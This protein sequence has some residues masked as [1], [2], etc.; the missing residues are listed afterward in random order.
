MN[1]NKK[2]HCMFSVL[3]VF[4]PVHS[5]LTVFRTCRNKKS[6]RSSQPGFPVTAAIRAAGFSRGCN[7]FRCPDVGLR[8]LNVFFGASNL[9]F[10]PLRESLVHTL[11]LHPE[12]HS[13][14]S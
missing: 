10:M 8:Q 9:T 14:A 7:L 13:G 6:P 3:F 5:W 4:I 12:V 1:T 2:T 11:R